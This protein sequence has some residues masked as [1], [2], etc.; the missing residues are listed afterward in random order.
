[1]FIV[2]YQGSGVSG[3]LSLQRPGGFSVL[4]DPSEVRWVAA[5]Y[6]ILQRSGVCIV[7]T[8]HGSGV[9]VYRG[10]VCSVYSINP[11]ELRYWVVLVYCIKPKR[12]AMF[13]VRMSGV[14]GVLH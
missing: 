5:I 9:T 6:M 2:S 1:M 8:V 3:V 12:S 14:F 10:Q 13:D 4:Y 11:P 7:L